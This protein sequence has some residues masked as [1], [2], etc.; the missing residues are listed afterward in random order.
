MSTPNRTEAT[1]RDSAEQVALVIDARREILLR[2][3]SHRLR[4]EDLEDCLSQAALELV[5][6]ARAGAR[7]AGRAHIS[8]VL[9]QRFLSRV[10]DRRRALE[11]RSAAQAAFER[12][13]NA[14]AFSGA[15]EEVPDPRAE[16]EPLVLARDE[17]RQV[18]MHAEDLSEDQRLV[19]ASQ[20]LEMECSAFCEQF[21]W[22]R[23]KYRKVAQRA[24]ARL[25]RLIDGEGG[26]AQR[27]VDAGE[28]DFRSAVP[29][30]GRQS[31]E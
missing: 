25:R 12:A 2:A 8:R 3:H 17:L 14:G 6:R 10:H 21:G 13:L 22:S 24:R 15:E 23:E 18:C 7:F 19:L 27:R 9:E 31:D 11:G 29:P 30:G 4:K 16:V 1:G 26:T 20:V 5:T 28:R